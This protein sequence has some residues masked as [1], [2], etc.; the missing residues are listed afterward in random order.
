MTQTHHEISKR[1]TF[2]NS[3]TGKVRR[4]TRRQVRRGKRSYLEDALYTLH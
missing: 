3:F 4:D 2:A 1:S